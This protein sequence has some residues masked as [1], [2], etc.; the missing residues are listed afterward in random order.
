MTTTLKSK[1]AI[2]ALVVAGLAFLGGISLRCPCPE[3]FVVGVLFT[4]VAVFLSSRWSIRIIAVCLCAASVTM[5][6]RARIRQYEDKQRVD[7]II[8]ALPAKAETNS[9]SK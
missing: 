9:I 6:A 1:L 3:P 7:R 8:K 5:A 4:L 2:G